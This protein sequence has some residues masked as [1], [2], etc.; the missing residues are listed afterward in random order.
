MKRGRA[1]A[2]STGR[3]CADCHGNEAV[4]RI[5]AGESVPMMRYE[6]GAIV[7]WKGVVPVVAEGLEWTYLNRRGEAWEPVANDDP[8]TVQYVEYGTPLSAEQVRKMAMP[9][10]K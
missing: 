10:K 4:R 9:L 6:D 7:N 2:Y 1:V 5:K 3:P 8:P